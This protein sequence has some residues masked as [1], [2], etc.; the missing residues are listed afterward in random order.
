MTIENGKLVEE[1]VEM[2]RRAVG[3]PAEHPLLPYPDAVTLAKWLNR[4]GGAEEFMAWHAKREEAIA[5]DA[6]DPFRSG[7][8]PENWREADEELRALCARVGPVGGVVLYLSGR[9]RVGKSYYAHK[10]AVQ[11]LMKYPDIELLFLA[12]TVKSSVDGQQKLVWHWLPEEVKRMNGTMTDTVKVKWSRANGFPD[13]KLIVPGGGV[14]YFD[15]YAADPGKWEGFEFGSRQG[16]AIAVV[17][18]E[19]MPLPWLEVVQRRAKYRNGIVLW[20][21]TPT[22]GITPT[23]KELLGGQPKPVKWS[24]APM[25]PPGRVYVPGVPAGQMPTVAL[26]TAK[27]EAAAVY[28]HTSP[29]GNYA[30]QVAQDCA[31]KTTDYVKRMGYGWAEDLGGRAF[32]TF[33]QWN[34]VEPEELPAEGT[35][36]LLVDPAGSRPWASIWVRVAPGNPGKL[37]VYR[38]WPDVQR[39]GEWAVPTSRATT[40]DSKKG[41][42]GDAGPAYHW[43][44]G[45]GPHQ[46]KRVWLEAESIGPAEQERDPHRRKLALAGKTAEVIQE[47]YGDPRAMA[48]QQA[49][50]R[51]AVTIFDMLAQPWLDGH[52]AELAPPMFFIPVPVREGVSHQLQEG[53]GLL[54]ELLFW[55]QSRP[56]MP[57]VNEPR[58]YVSRECQQVRWALDNYTG[59]GGSDAPSKDWIDLLSYMAFADLRYVAPWNGERRRGWGGYGA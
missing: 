6:A 21:Y 45:Y 27:K 22:K 39:H 49:A 30:Q 10:R 17:A 37:Y 11:D 5:V 40:D 35:N 54:N 29:Y 57:Q 4:P 44:P 19:N 3:V 56:L 52:G 31:G 34:V 59:K 38:D 58:L 28:F 14:A 48:T 18:D 51:G 53:M 43:S 13:A 2:V 50:E 32:P 1:L 41:W 47:R 9:N 8:E 36:Y 25:L 42:D 7:L 26:S 46:Y 33:G 16:R 55:D 12:E 23:I 15:S 24:P 20:C